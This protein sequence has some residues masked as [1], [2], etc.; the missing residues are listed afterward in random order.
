[1][2]YLKHKPNTHRMLA[3]VLGTFPAS[4]VIFTN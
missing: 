2:F 4:W 1:M 3:K